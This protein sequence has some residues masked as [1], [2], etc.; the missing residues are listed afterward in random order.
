MI[1]TI[2]ESILR[3]PQYYIKTQS[4]LGANRLREKCI[5]IIKPQPSDCILDIGCGPGQVLDYIP[6]PKQYYGFDTEKKYIEYA[7][8][9]YSGRGKFFS[10]E[11]NSNFLVSTKLEPIDKVF[12]LGILHHISNENA[13][14][15]LKLIYTVLKPKGSIVSV[16]PCF[17]PNQ[18]LVSRFIANNDRGKFVRN[19]VGYRSLTKDLFTEIDIQIFN[20]VCR[21]PSTEI[22]MHLTKDS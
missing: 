11:F 9:K 18:S 12:L 15:L 14:E 3:H 7:S 8:K 22:I 13:L 10:C 6:V 4:L 1:H 16:D 19:E 21:I 2:L 17:T 20:N 5:A